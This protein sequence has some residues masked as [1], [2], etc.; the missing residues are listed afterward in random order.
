MH[1]TDNITLNRLLTIVARQGASDL[2]LTVGTPPVIRKEG[3]LAQLENEDIVTAHFLERIMESFIT[4]ESRVYLE[5]EQEVAVTYTFNKILR[6]RIHVYRQKGNYSIALRYIPFLNKKITDVQL[7]AY[8]ERVVCNKTG[9]IIVTGAYDS[10]KSTT[11]A[12][13]INTVNELGPPRYVVTLER[14]I[15][16]IFANNKCII[17]QREV[18][19]DVASYVQGLQLVL[20]NDIDM[21]VMD[22]LETAEVVKKV[23][24]VLE[25]GR[26][27]IIILDA[28]FTQHALT[29]VY[30]FVDSQESAWARKVLGTHLQ[31]VLLQKL[32][33]KIGGGR[34]LAYELLVNSGM[35]PS[36]LISGNIDRLESVF[37]GQKEGE[38]VLLEESLA[39]LVQKG[40]VKLEE[41]LQE[42]RDR[43]YLKSLLR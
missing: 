42:A 11:V 40:E 23:L 25:G 19:K 28:T 37:K 6:F 5:K 43:N 15:E 18:G 24:E 17:E 22:R 34:A 1:T 36:I 29:R 39:R 14:P 2:H 35:V 4:D 20:E 41:A 32:V 16:Y 12:A 33:H 10:G 8:L 21:V 7:P 3:A 38:T 13:M 31:C 9:L 30:N 27:V 26:T